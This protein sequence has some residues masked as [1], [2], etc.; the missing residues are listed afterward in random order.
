MA[1]ADLLRFISCMRSLSASGAESAPSAE[2]VILL[3]PRAGTKEVY[4]TS[5]SSSSKIVSSWLMYR[6]LRNEGTSSRC[7][8]LEESA[9]EAVWLLAL[10]AGERARYYGCCCLPRGEAGETDMCV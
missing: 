1:R 7:S 5:C 9:V 2:L 8:I 3:R 6:A 10:L 4:V